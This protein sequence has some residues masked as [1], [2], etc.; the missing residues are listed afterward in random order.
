MN[1][2]TI[3]INLIDGTEILGKKVTLGQNLTGFF[4]YFET[5]NVVRAIRIDHIQ[6]I[7]FYEGADHE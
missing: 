1:L 7:D 3:N 6:M 2:N 5:E 4:T